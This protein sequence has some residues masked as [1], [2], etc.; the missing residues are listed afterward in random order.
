MDGR[1]GGGFLCF[2]GEFFGCTSPAGGHDL[3]DQLGVDGL[4]WDLER[5][6]FQ[7]RFLKAQHQLHPSQWM[8]PKGMPGEEHFIHS[9]WS[10]LHFFGSHLQCEQEL[11]LIPSS[12][13]WL[14]GDIACH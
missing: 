10:D 3:A 14:L 11:S 5:R 2:D 8:K 7:L 12:G 9:R 6:S 13:P 4:I 1:H